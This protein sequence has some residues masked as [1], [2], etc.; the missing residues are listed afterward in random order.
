MD[1]TGRTW[2]R[3]GTAVTVSTTQ[4]KYG[5]SSLY[6]PVQ[7]YIEADYSTDFYF[8]D[9]DFCIESW[10]YQLDYTRCYV[11]QWGEM[12]TYGFRLGVRPCGTNGMRFEVVWNDG[13]DSFSLNYDDS[14]IQAIQPNTWFH[15]A[16][17]RYG[18]T[19]TLYLNGVAVASDTAV[20]MP[21]AISCV[22]P[23]NWKFYVTKSEVF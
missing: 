12:S 16:V 5:V 1:E 4:K 22:D 20:T 15:V 2:V 7:H 10:V 14:V 23:S 13:S 19:I 21:D 17:S 3:N 8:A 11:F 18:S 6:T 9:G